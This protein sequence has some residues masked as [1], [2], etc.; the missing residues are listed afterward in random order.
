M[1][2]FYNTADREFVD[3]FLFQPNLELAQGVLAKRDAEISDAIGEGEILG[4]PIFNYNRQADSDYA[5][6]VRD[7][8]E[9]KAKEATDYILNNPTDFI[10][11]KKRI[12]DL[13]NEL[14]RDF[15]MG[16]IFKLQ[17]N[18]DTINAWQENLSKKEDAGDR[19]LYNTILTDYYNNAGGYG[20]R[21]GIYNGPELYD[22]REITFNAFVENG[23]FKHL[24]I[25][26]E[27]IEDVT[28][29]GGWL[30]KK[31]DLAIELKP[32]TIQA[33]F[34]SYIKDN[35]NAVG[36]ASVGQQ[37]FG[38]NDWFDEN[39]NLSFAPGSRLGES[40]RQGVAATA[41]KHT[42]YTE[43]MSETH[44]RKAATDYAYWKKQ[45]DYIGNAEIQKIASADLDVS[46]FAK[47]NHYAQEYERNFIDQY[48]EKIFQLRMAQDPTQD[49]KKVRDYINN[50]VGNSFEDLER[51]VA[52]R[53]LGTNRDGSK[54]GIEKAL[55]EGKA[56]IA[57]LHRAGWDHL[58]ASGLE[59]KQVVA[60]QKDFNNLYS[61]YSGD[62]KYK[63]EEGAVYKDAVTGEEIDMSKQ[64][65][66]EWNPHEM[67]G[68]IVEL[69]GRGKVKLTN[70]APVENSLTIIPIN[71]PGKTGKSLMENYAVG[72]MNFEYTPVDNSGNVIDKEDTGIYD[73]RIFVDMQQSTSIGHGVE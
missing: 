39:G 61:K 2:R 14:E 19:E 8:Y 56:Y 5:Q 3:D 63:V 48:K 11:H 25:N 53:K 35:P 4:N 60:A 12:A 71:S 36:R 62:F 10:G 72:K 58:I 33:G 40:M 17:T 57:T 23:L 13:R 46:N 32:E 41:Y 28:V 49:P 43:D 34:Q 64:F 42:K 54:S 52:S 24:G 73:L 68:K 31:G 67:I 21:N 50:N 44:A 9:Q 27:D 47:K 51:Y 69:P 1:A 65:E 7:R 6:E 15:Q 26:K 66:G 20:A 70:F 29:N 59:P 55:E 22:S 38:E 37:Y 18:Y 45:Q 16:D 30:V